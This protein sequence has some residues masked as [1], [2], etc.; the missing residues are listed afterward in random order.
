MGISSLLGK[1]TVVKCNLLFIVYRN[2]TAIVGRVCCHCISGVTPPPPPPP[3]R[4]SNRN[5]F[6]YCFVSWRSWHQCHRIFSHYTIPLSYLKFPARLK[7]WQVSEMTTTLV[8]YKV[9]PE[10]CVV[11]S[12]K[13]CRE[14]PRKCL[15]TV[16]QIFALKRNEREPDNQEIS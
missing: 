5:S 13:K 8:A 4:K 2:K 10:L 11:T 14:R 1:Q 16:T 6:S 9:R 7:V 3:P 12:L 15:F